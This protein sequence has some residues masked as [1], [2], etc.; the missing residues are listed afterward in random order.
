MKDKRVIGLICGVAISIILIVIA[1]INSSK[2]NDEKAEE[3]KIRVYNN[4]TGEITECSVVLPAISEVN[5]IAINDIV[6]GNILDETELEKYKVEN[7]QAYQYA[8]NGVKFNL[9]NNNRIVSV[10]F[11]T[12]VSKN[13]SSISLDD[14][15][16]TFNG[17]Q[18]NKKEE[19]LKWFK[20]NTFEN[21][22]IHIDIEQNDEYIN[23]FAYDVTYKP[24]IIE[25]NN[26]DIHEE[27][28]DK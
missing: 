12:L 24:T 11:Y 7:N 21:S 25:N 6:I 13:G 5:T 10:A 20:N 17:R 26:D 1:I 23:I 22:M 2:T 18:S 14:I 15:Y 8:K 3:N 28:L 16:I 27:H 19:I 4:E 9:D